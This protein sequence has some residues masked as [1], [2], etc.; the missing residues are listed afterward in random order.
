M[1]FSSLVLNPAMLVFGQPITVT[2]VASRP[3]AAPY[4]ARGS[5][6][7]KPVTIQLECSQDYHQTQELAL[8]VRLADFPVAPVQGD[9]ITMAQGAFVVFNVTLDGQ[10]GADLFLR[11]T[12][13]A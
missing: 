5:F 8:G 3:G 1:D 4:A 11:E 12:D 10:G 2:P 13:R 7:S 9:T 6:S